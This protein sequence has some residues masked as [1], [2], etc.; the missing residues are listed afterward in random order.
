MVEIQIYLFNSFHMSVFYSS[1]TARELQGTGF[2]FSRK[3]PN[4]KVKVYT[5]IQ[6]AK[7]FLKS[8]KVHLSHY[9]KEL[10]L[11]LDIIKVIK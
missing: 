9:L 3:D 8:E 2:T 1:V 5:H 10:S 6:K 7:N 11:V 4:G